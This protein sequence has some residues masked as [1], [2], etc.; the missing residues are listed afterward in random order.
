M[1]TPWKIRP[2][3]ID[4]I[5]GKSIVLGMHGYVGVYW[6]YIY[7]LREYIEYTGG[8]YVHGYVYSLREYIGYTGGTWVCVFSGGVHGCTG[9]HG[10]VYSL[11]EYMGVRGYMGM[12]IL[13]G[14]TWV[15]GGTWVC[16]FSRGV[17][18][19]YWGYNWVH[20]GT[21]VC[22]FSRGVH[23]CTG[24]RVG[25]TGGYMGNSTYDKNWKVV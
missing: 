3:I 6:G 12:C 19:V 14:S 4:R 7:S 17:H 22:V 1:S 8:T 13:W 11:G 15:Y 5:S 24:V 21:W 20:G 9:V 23:G 18:W 16:V 25:I 2:R 10:Y